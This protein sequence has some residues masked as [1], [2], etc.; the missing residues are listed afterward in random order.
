MLKF[1]N[2]N[3]YLVLEYSRKLTI[4]IPTYNRYTDLRIALGAIKKQLSNIDY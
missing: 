1:S 3:K 2:Y 4:A